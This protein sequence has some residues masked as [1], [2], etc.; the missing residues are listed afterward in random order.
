[1]SSSVF[2]SLTSTK[3]V[4]GQFVSFLKAAPVQKKSKALQ[5]FHPRRFNSP[6]L[7]YS[8]QILK[9]EPLSYSIYMVEINDI[10]LV[11]EILFLFKYCRISLFWRF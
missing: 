10:E 7:R 6:Q 3:P 4:F 1:M 11:R 8:T 2:L 5:R 9:L